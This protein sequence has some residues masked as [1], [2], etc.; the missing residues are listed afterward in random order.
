MTLLHGKIVDG[1]APD[2]AA[3][4]ALKPKLTPDEEETV[5]LHLMRQL[6]GDEDGDGGGDGGRV[7]HFAQH[8]VSVIHQKEMR[9]YGRL[10]NR[11]VT[12]L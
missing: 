3:F 10:T 8:R 7:C 11:V 4:A 6:A 1:R 12:I 2:P 9:H 5:R